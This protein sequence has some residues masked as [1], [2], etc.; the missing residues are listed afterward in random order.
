[1]RASPGE[2]PPTNAALLEKQFDNLRRHAARPIAWIGLPLLLHVW[3]L[4]GPFCFDD[5]NL[6]L[7]AERYLAGESTDPSLF[8]FAPDADAW[9]HL[10]RTG[11]YPWWSPADGRADFF[12]P[13]AEAAF[14]LDMKL[15]GRRAWAHRMMSLAVFIAALVLLHRLFLRIGADPLRAGLATMMFGVS[16]AAAQPAT[17]ISNRSDLLVLIGVC[18]AAHAFVPLIA[19]ATAAR[20]LRAWAA[21]ATVG[22]GF[23]GALLSKEIAIGWAGTITLF[24]IWRRIRGDKTPQPRLLAA[25]LALTLA[26]LAAYVAYYAGSRTG[27][28]SRTAL[29]AGAPRSSVLYLSLWLLGAPINLL[30]NRGLDTTIPL[31][32]GCLVTLVFIAP[33]VRRLLAADPAARFF[34][35]WA[36]A[37]GAIALLT[38]PEARALCLA[39]PGWTY[40]LAHL[41]LPKESAA[42]DGPRPPSLMLRHHL[43]FSNGGIGMAAAVGIVVVSMQAE[44]RAQSHIQTNVASLA[45][46]L[47]DGDTLILPAP[48][49]DLEW[50]AAGDRL[51]FLTS[52]RNVALHFLHAADAQARIN[53]VDAHTLRVALDQDETD[54]AWNKCS[55]LY[56]YWM[57]RPSLLDSALAARMLGAG[58]TPRIGARFELPDITV[59]ITGLKENRI[60]ELTF[61]FA[62]PLDDP[63]LHIATGE[64]SP[65]E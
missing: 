41:L 20:P 40:F 54:R 11:S 12:R 3:S 65:R 62:R 28:G 64:S 22:L 56:R 58:W 63:S 16:Q 45:A 9:Q 61:R 1:M 50:L 7:K 55:W 38:S 4:T 36:V 42:P 6:V 30:T 29:L 39:T 27:A 23:A 46:P 44:R 13:L 34:L 10:R 60:T 35:C 48:E 15:F 32:A 43:L 5:L 49:I 52:R 33:H 8:R 37:F 14:Y 24:E 53:R 19:P 18:I 26:L 2:G 59:E 47:R 25:M 21:L 51:Q 31:A 17:F 57:P